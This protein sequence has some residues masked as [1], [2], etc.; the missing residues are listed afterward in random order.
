MKRGALARWVFVSTLSAGLVGVWISA[1]P[2]APPSP[3]RPAAPAVARAGQ[4]R[5]RILL[6][7]GDTEPTRWDGS[8]RVTGGKIRGI[9]IWRPAADDG[10]G[11]QTW[12]VSSHRLPVAP[13]AAQPGPMVEN[14]VLVTAE[15]LGRGAKFDIQTGHGNFTFTV[16]QTGFGQ[17]RSFL[18]GRA[19]VE[20]VPLTTQITDSLEEQD[21]PAVAQSGDTVYIAYVEFTHGDRS[22]RWPRLIAERPKSFEGLA[23]PTGGDQVRLIEYS[24]ANRTWSEPAAVSPVRLDVYRTAVAVDGEG[25]VW[26][27]WSADARGNFDLYARYRKN[28]LWSDEMRLTQDPGPDLNPVAVTDSTGAVWIAWQ[29]YR[30]D[31]FEILVAR[32]RGTGFSKEERVSFSAANDW[33]PQMAASK[34]GDVAVVWDTY[35]KGDYDVYLRRLRWS[36]RIGMDTPMPIAAT[37]KFEARPSVAYDVEGRIWV[38]YEEGFPRWGKD[39][40]AYETTGSG[41]YQSSNVQVKIVEGSQYFT[42]GDKLQETLEA[43]PQAP[44][45]GQAGGPVSGPAAQAARAPADLPDPELVKERRPNN[46]PYAPNLQSKG[47]PRLVNDGQGIM[48]LAYRAGAPLTRSPLG[49]TWVENLAYFDGKEWTGPILLPRSD[50]ILDNRPALLATGA[51]SLLVVGSTDHRAS[52]LREVGSS[53]P[54][55]AMDDFN[56]D[57]VVAELDTRT[58]PKTPDLIAV[59]AEK[60]EEPEP[61]VKAEKEQV[62][63]MRSYRVSLGNEKLQLLRG[64]FHRHTELSVDGGRDGP[65]IDAYRYM[66]DAAY[67]DWVACCDHDNGTGREYTWWTIQKLTD[68]FFL[69]GRFTSMFGYERSVQ[70]PEGH[71]NVVM[72]RRGVRPLSRLMPKMA[73]DSPPSRAPD[74]QMLYDYLRSFDGI[75]A[76]HTSGTNM[77]TDWRDNDPRVEP[78]VEIYQGDRQNYEMPDAPRSNAAKDSIGGWRPLGFVSLAL[79]KGYRLAFE[80]SSD[81]ISTH[82][83]YCNLWVTAPTRAAVME[84]FH[85]RRVYGAT[86][87]ILAEV[88]AG[89]QGAG[90]FMGE[91]FRITGPPTIHV[92]LAGTADFAKVHIIKDGNYVY[93]ASPRSRSVDFTWRDNAAKAGVTSYYYVRG[94]QTDGELV[95]VSPMWITVE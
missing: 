25:R 61:D 62:A 46:T 74:T 73:D 77:G 82:M 8:V 65:L 14:G 7:Q 49:S 44:A 89:P 80:A 38:A 21:Y 69:P 1:T 55:R 24:K 94:E 56:N 81:H 3:A 40:G 51:G 57:L 54:N 22:L 28:G 83:S 53:L 60:P 5:F 20:Q 50:N 29:G 78:V 72:A 79:K 36:G 32:Q 26:V 75:V 48:F 13:G 59:P 47:F 71:R 84:A 33:D 43:P 6:G 58:L 2:Q 70:Y 23:V 86:D 39:F 17:P 68:A 92:K 11:G 66:L 88:T 42:T 30:R 15:L 95:W 18:A 37:Q 4:V 16:D 10:A 35:D 45:R 64:E 27:F 19:N 41:L 63:L 90:H 93:A 12:K 52:F 91:E 31:N 85:K 87:N 67:M 76:S 9:E 34:N